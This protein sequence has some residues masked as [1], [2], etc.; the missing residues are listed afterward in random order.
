V[1][2][3]SHACRVAML[4]LEHKGVPYR[5]VVVPTGLHPVAVRLLGFPGSPAPFRYI[6]GRPHRSIALADRLGTVP[7]LRLG[8]ERLQ[9]N[10]AIARRLDELQPD[11]PLFPGRSE[12]RHA[13]EEA[14]CWGDEV[15]QMAARRL[16]LAASLH[17]RDGLVERGGD[18]RLGALLWRHDYARLIG[19][20]YLGRFA[21][22]A[23]GEAE[24]DLLAS[25]PAMLDRIDGWVE[26]GVLNGERLYAADFMIVPSLALLHYRRDLRPE[27]EAR[28]SMQLL[29]RVLPEP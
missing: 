4:M 2:L 14:E 9:T 13:V 1:I 17:G 11:P 26:A 8:D 7:A 3:G 23:H 21:F 28:V 10:R 15:L 27:L 5:R 12:A 16:V 6:D 22:A 29:D 20:R 18:G 25:L 19:A 24:R